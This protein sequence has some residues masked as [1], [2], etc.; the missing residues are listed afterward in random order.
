M[1]SIWPRR[2]ATAEVIRLVALDG[3]TTLNLVHRLEQM[4][5]GRGQRFLHRDP[6]GE[7]ERELR[8]VDAVIAAVDQRDRAV[9]HLEAERAFVHRFAHAFLD[10]RN[11]L[12]GNR[13][14]VDPLLELEALAARQRLHFDDHVAELAVAA[15]LLLVAA[16]LGDRLADQFA[17]ADRRRV[18]LHLDS[19]AALQP[20][21][22]RCSDARR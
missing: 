7:A 15:R 2:P 20:R 21:D 10:R 9:D 11:P 18:A 13:A 1:P 19:V 17:I 3:Q 6:P 5:L 8:A 12:L 16:L 22:A 14:A 4:R